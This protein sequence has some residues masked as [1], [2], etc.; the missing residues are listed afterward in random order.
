ME[1]ENIPII[2]DIVIAVITALGVLAVA[3]SLHHARTANFVAA[4]LAISDR[5]Q[6]DK[7]V[8]G[9]VLLRELY[10]RYKDRTPADDEIVQ[11]FTEMAENYGTAGWYKDIKEVVGQHS[12]VNARAGW[13]REE[14]MAPA[15]GEFDLVAILAIHSRI[16]GLLDVVVQ[17]WL[18]SII[19]CWV[20][21]SW[22]VTRRLTAKRDEQFQ[23]FSALYERALHRKEMLARLESPALIG[24]PY[25]HSGRWIDRLTNQPTYR[26]ANEAA[27]RR[28]DLLHSSN[29]RLTHQE[30]EGLNMTTDARPDDAQ[31]RLYGLLLDQL[32]KYNT[33]IWQ[34][35]TALAAVN[36]LVLD[37]LPE[38]PYALIAIA[39]F[40][41]VLIFALHKLNV[42]HRAIIAT[43]RQAEA[44]L[45][46]VFPSFIPQFPTSRVRA[47]ALIVWVLGL[48]DSV[49][50]FVALS[51][52]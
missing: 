25:P 4:W 1:T 14:V 37:R 43:T 31:I 39:I 5:L 6:A 33:V 41:A 23:C 2:V 12:S 24:D 28:A 50:F 29:D 18:D 11:T 27:K 46:K 45:T 48:L 26:D 52:L 10:F 21:G 20:Q 15:V 34:F 30:E 49:L 22:V 36:I 44:E 3:F 9:R 40:N 19:A 47:P 42:Q 17:E 8:R 32:T 7:S 35:P 16:P 51:A 38:E 13:L